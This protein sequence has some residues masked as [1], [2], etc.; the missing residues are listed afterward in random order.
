MAV[1][2]NI[3]DAK[4]GKLAELD[5]VE[6]AQTIIDLSHRMIHEGKHY[7]FSYVDTDFDIADA[8]E[9]L[10]VVGSKPAHISAEV[11]AGK[12]TLLQAYE[13]A[14]H[15]PA[16]EYTAYNNNRVLNT[17]PTTRLY[18]HN[19]GGADG[20]L[21]WTSA[22]GLSANPTNFAGG[23]ARA[24]DEW[25]LRPNTNYLFK[26]STGTDNSFLTVHLFWYEEDI[27]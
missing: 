14:T 12:D 6:Q 25:I 2:I 10:I 21:I 16:V 19:D 27:D 11:I 15:A 22:F 13:G 7:T 5:R 18:T 9:V 23:I 8:I 24:D 17:P 3:A 1:P 26:V 20:T 4:S